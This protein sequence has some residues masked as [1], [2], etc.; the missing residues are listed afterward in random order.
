MVPDPVPARRL[1]ARAAGAYA[2]DLARILAGARLNQQYPDAAAVAGWVA[3][4]A[5][6]AA[7]GLWPGLEVDLRSGLPAPAAWAQLRADLALAPASLGVLR[8]RPELEARARRYPRGPYQDHLRRHDH[9]TALLGLPPY[10]LEALRVSPR[11]E[12][13][14]GRAE[15][16]QL[17][18]DTLGVDGLPARLGLHLRV[19]PTKRG[20]P[21][22]RMQGDAAVASAP[23]AARLRSLGGRDALLLFALLAEEPGLTPLEL[24]RG[25][26]GP[27]FVGGLAEDGPAAESGAP[28]VGTFG[29][30]RVSDAGAARDNDPLAACAPPA[31][32][33]A[34]AEALA[35]AATRL[36]ARLF[37]DR[38]LVV[39][40]ALVEAVRAWC[41]RRGTRNVIYGLEAP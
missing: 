38:K 30:E 40:G 3:C 15:S 34:E 21:A 8:P 37:R 36:G 14:G 13:E 27:V 19:A 12:G 18:L 11:H 41:A 16:F 22:V 9:Y 4:M 24:T 23:F 6:A 10:P 20:P 39:P 31:R 29:L 33:P 25:S 35:R 26:L 32:T 1:D 7:S 5:Q 2:R 28:F 17:T